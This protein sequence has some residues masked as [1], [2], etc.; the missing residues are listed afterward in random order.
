MKSN[1]TI[2][3]NSKRNGK[4]E[5]EDQFPNNTR[6]DKKYSKDM[7]KEYQMSDQTANYYLSQRSTKDWRD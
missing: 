7:L 2:Y 6:Q 4:I 1:K 5:T 3:I